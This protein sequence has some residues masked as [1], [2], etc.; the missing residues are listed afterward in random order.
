M[1]S[2]I[3]LMELASKID[4][5]LIEAGCT[6]RELMTVC[7]LTMRANSIVAILSPSKIF[8]PDPGTQ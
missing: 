1:K 8:S 4:R 7:E 5:E 2:A 3:E 6:D